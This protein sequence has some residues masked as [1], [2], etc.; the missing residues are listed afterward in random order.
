MEIEQETKEGGESSK[1]EEV[2]KSDA[3]TTSSSN[4]FNIPEDMLNKILSKMPFISILNFRDVCPSSRTVLRSFISSSS[5]SQVHLA[6]WM[7]LPGKLEDKES[8]RFCTYE[9]E[10]V[11]KRTN[12]PPEFYDDLCLGTSYGWMVMLDKDI[13]PYLF[14]LFSLKKIKL[15][16]IDTFLNIVCVTGPIIENGNY[17]F[18]YEGRRTHLKK[19]RSVHQLWHEFMYK[20][21][22]SAKPSHNNGDFYVLVIIER[23]NSGTA[24][25]AFCY[26]GDDEWMQ[27]G[28]YN[29]SY[30]D[31]VCHDNMF[32]A[33]NY[34]DKVEIWDVHNS[35]PTKRTNI[36]AAF[37][38]KIFDTKSSLRNFNT[39][40]NYLVEVS[41]DLF[42]VVR[43][44]GG[45][46]YNC[47]LYA[48]ELKHETL[49]FQVYKL[50]TSKK[51]WEEV[52]S[53]G[54]LAY[55]VGAN[56]S[57][58]LSVH[59]NSAYK[60][61]SIYFTDDSWDMIYWNKKHF[62]VGVYHMEDKSIERKI[63]FTS[64]SEPPPFW[65]DPESLID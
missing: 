7:L 65:I 44:I 63:L 30:C 14:N 1:E 5:Y 34:P 59:G 62:D 57:K 27:L 60:A 64:Y 55:F 8:I 51:R 16:N 10:M 38:Q 11:F 13:E 24:Q 39:F 48:L 21:V 45:V 36:V 20:A 18:Y 35:H 58:S 29:E 2:G 31:V 3:L 52:E 61:N 9:D 23:G 41:T 22:V 33:L 19:I 12:A 54:D 25:L 4:L 26:A 28:G 53:L 50:D 47:G 6:P 46:L 15:P 17:I 40:R 42:L 32:Y 56:Q 43:F 37:P 49:F